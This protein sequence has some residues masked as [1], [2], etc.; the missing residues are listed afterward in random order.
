[1]I[2]EACVSVF[3]QISLLSLSCLGS[4]ILCLNLC[5]ET[6][7][8]ET[9]ICL[10][11]KASHICQKQLEQKVQLVSPWFKSKIYLDTSYSYRYRK[12]FTRLKLTFFENR[13]SN[14][15]FKYV[16]D[17]LIF[18]SG[19]KIDSYYKTVGSYEIF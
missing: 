7:V 18:Q 16:E 10:S 11:A 1:M 19:I 5:Y 8:Y 14:I 2:I 13:N 17:K 9:S 6:W 12:A 15:L 3:L 4:L